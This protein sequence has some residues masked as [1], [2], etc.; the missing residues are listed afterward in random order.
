MGRN[1]EVV[2][3]KTAVVSDYIKTWVVVRF[4]R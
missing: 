3:R 2:S 1:M 4:Q